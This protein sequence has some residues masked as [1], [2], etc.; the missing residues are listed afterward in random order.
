MSDRFPLRRYGAAVFSAVLFSLAIPNEVFQWG[1]P[2]LSPFILTPLFWGLEG[3]SLPQARRMLVL[4]GLVFT[5]TSNYW[6]AFFGDYSIWT[7]GG[8]TLGYIPYYLFLSHFL[9]DAARRPLPLRPL[10]L[11]AVWTVFEYCKSSG[12]LG[13]PWGLLPYPLHG[14]L[15]L[16]QVSDL[17]GIWPLTFLLAWMSALLA[18]ILSPPAPPTPSRPTPSPLP[19]LA[20]AGLL[21]AVFLAYG[22]VRMYLIPL[23]ERGAFTAALIQHNADSWDESPDADEESILT[24]ERLSLE[25]IRTTPEVDLVVWSET[26]LTYP[27]NYRPAF[28]ERRP[29]EKPFFAFLVELNRPLLT[30]SPYREKVGEEVRYYN[31]VLLIGPDGAIQGAYKKK[32][33]VPMAEHIPFWD[34]PLIQHFFRGTIRLY[35]TWEPGKENTVFTL[36][37]EDG[38]LVRFGTPICFEDAFTV[39]N[40][41]LVRAGAEVLINLTNDS[42]SRTVSA[43]VQHFVAA[44]FQA[45]ALK[46]TMVRSTNSGYTCVIDPWGRVRADLPM[47]TPAYLTARVPLYD[48]PPTLYALAGDLLPRLLFLWVIALLLWERGRGGMRTPHG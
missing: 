27:Y 4:F 25:A 20:A 32:H 24:A 1:M 46:T 48:R 44:R 9:W 10:L 45:A 40:R 35:G 37:L 12:Y 13:Y 19:Q 22:L 18:D 7:I 42:W 6:L 36:P 3:A 31:S 47:F 2:L 21:L 30:G 39:I 8:V 43:Q 23:P 14:I 34:V 26:V 11:A 29:A 33:L 16:I 15:P 38:T 17:L 28:Y 5:L 41:A